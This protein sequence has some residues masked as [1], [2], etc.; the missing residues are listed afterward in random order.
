M[1]I[2]YQRVK[3]LV[4]GFV[5]NSCAIQSFE[6]L[7]NTYL[8]WVFSLFLNPWVLIFKILNLESWLLTLDFLIESWILLDSYL[9]LLT[10]SWFTWDVLWFTWV[11]LW[12]I[13]GLFV[14]HL[15]HQW[16][17]WTRS[18][19]RSTTRFVDYEHPNHVYRLKKALYSLKQAPRSWHDRLSSFL[20]EQSFT[21]G[22]VD[23]TLFIKKVSIEFLIVQIHVDDIIF[24]ATN[25]ILCKEF[26][27]CM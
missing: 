26:S 2:D 17:H 11:V 6:K 25:E 10:C 16:S 22:Q 21:R 3:T 1:V 15:C 14:H 19:C 4:K 20:T 5:K 9:E 24:G 27:S 18:V 12:L 13:F 7:F 8:D 23:K